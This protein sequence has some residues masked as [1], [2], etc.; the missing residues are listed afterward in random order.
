MKRLMGLEVH[1]DGNKKVIPWSTTES[2][3]ICEIKADINLVVHWKQ[4]L[5]LLYTSF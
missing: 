4:D 5:R 1:E 2:S 3:G